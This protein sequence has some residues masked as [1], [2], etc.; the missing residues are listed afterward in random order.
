MILGLIL[1]YNAIG[2]EHF[3]KWALYG[4]ILTNFLIA[5]FSLI[6]ILVMSDL[7]SMVV[8]TLDLAKAC[9]GVSAFIFLFV[10]I[11]FS[12]YL[13]AIS[14]QYLRLSNMPIKSRRKEGV[15][16]EDLDHQELAGITM[17]IAAVVTFITSPMLLVGTLALNT[18]DF[19]IICLPIIVIV[20][21]IAIWITI[22]LLK[23]RYRRYGFL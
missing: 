16:D 2:L 17:F 10:S 5:T 1:M 9:L 14:K 3:K 12:F 15:Y 6:I 23:D 7:W 18:T 13:L 20:D 8:I 19:I 4:S 11:G 21:I 22:K